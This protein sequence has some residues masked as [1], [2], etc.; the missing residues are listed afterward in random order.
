MLH[1]HEEGF[2]IEVAKNK[3]LEKPIINGKQEHVTENGMI[4]CVLGLQAGDSHCPA[5]I[6]QAQSRDC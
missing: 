6:A 5:A 2:A 3:S 1:P 4:F